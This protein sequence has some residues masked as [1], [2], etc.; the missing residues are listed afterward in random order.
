MCG[1]NIAAKIIKKAICV[2][3]TMKVPE[4]QD[5]FNAKKD[6]F[7]RNMFMKSFGKPDQH[8]FVVILRLT[9]R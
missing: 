3:V 5:R 6:K 7:V 9:S 1:L 2:S 4:N 8:A